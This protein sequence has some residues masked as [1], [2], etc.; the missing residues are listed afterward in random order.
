MVGC[1]LR[2]VWNNRSGCCP[3]KSVMR[4]SQRCNRSEWIHPAGRRP[5][6]SSRYTGRSQMTS[7]RAPGE[8][9]WGTRPWTRSH[10]PRLWWWELLPGWWACS[11]S[12]AVHSPGWCRAWTSDILLLLGAPEWSLWSSGHGSTGCRLG[13]PGSVSASSSDKVLWRWHTPPRDPSIPAH[14][15][16]C[17]C[18]GRTYTSSP[19]RWW[20]LRSQYPP[21]RGS[22]WESRSSEDRSLPWRKRCV[23]NTNPE[24]KW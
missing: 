13:A 5:F 16:F 9:L 24:L 8:R 15:S 10:T 7:D 19:S 4:S 20:W 21:I 6:P 3:G 2:P 1:L 22:W 18:L 23:K 14:P 12:S 11:W 17:K